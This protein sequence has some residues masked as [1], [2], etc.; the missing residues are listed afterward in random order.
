MNRPREEIEV[1]QLLASRGYRNQ[2]ISRAY[3][4]TFYSAEAALARVGISRSRHSG[5]ASAFGRLVAVD[6]DLER[7]LGRMLHD[8]LD[9]RNAVDYGDVRVEDAVLEGALRDAEAVVTAVEAW[10]ARR[11]PAG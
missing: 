1:A 7:A 8:L 5:V 2:A 11:A 9:L 4:A 6:P 3:Y 10:L